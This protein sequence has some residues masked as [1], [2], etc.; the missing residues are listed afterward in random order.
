MPSPL[1]ANATLARAMTEEELLQCVLDAARAL[2]W[3]S[4]HFRPAKTER[5][6]RTAVSGDGK[7]FPDLVLVHRRMGEVVY[8]ELK[9]ESGKTT[10]E[11]DEWIR[12]LRDAGQRVYVWRPS[13]WLGGEVM[14]V[15]EGAE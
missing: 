6:W 4:A 12:D 15:L 14:S 13:C 7:G 11:Q 2:S 5:G 1:T 3:R 8:V 9:R 10:P